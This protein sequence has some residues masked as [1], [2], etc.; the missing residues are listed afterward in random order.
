[1]ARDVRR[2]D[3]ER[4]R[5]NRRPAEDDEQ[6]DRPRKRRP[7][8]ED[9]DVD[10]RRRAK[11]GMSKGLLFGLIGGGVGLLVLIVVLI[12]ALRGGSSGGGEGNGDFS[13]PTAAYETLVKA[14]QSNDWGTIYDGG[15]KQQRS[16]FDSVA[17]HGTNGKKGRAAFITTMNEATK[18]GQKVGGVGSDFN[19]TTVPGSESIKGDPRDR[20]SEETGILGTSPDQLCE[21]KGVNGNTPFPAQWSAACV[22]PTRTRGRTRWC[23]IVGLL[24]KVVASCTARCRTR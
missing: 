7:A 9:E 1:M 13:T 6:D 19:G 24:V 2:E 22:P 17:S 5:K 4:P 11:Q 18:N 23:G 12:F 14:N 21:K 8:D 20:Q 3:D 10:R 15:D 16:Y